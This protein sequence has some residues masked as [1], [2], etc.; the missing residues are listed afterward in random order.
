MILNNITN[1]VFIDIGANIGATSI[2]LAIEN[3]E[4]CFHLF[5]PHSGVVEKL[6]SN[7]RLNDLTNCEV[8][9]SA[10]CSDQSGY[11]TFYAQSVLDENLGLSSIKKNHDI[12]NAKP[13]MVSAIKLNDVINSAGESKK[14]AA[15]KIDVQ[16]A[17][18]EVLSSGFDAIQAHR[19]I[20]LFEFESEYYGPDD[21]PIARI[22]ILK[23]FDTLKYKLYYVPRTGSFFPEVTLSSYF[24]GDILAV[25]EIIENRP[26][27]V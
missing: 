6:K 3:P 10:V 18:M 5:E 4:C 21:E 20:I 22:K 11:I 24:H 16:G 9:E 15:V 27:N 19:P 26:I 25:P 13:T 17:E 1:V 12:K 2:P 8:F 14:V 23:F 7:L